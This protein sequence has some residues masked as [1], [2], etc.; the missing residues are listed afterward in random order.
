MQKMVQRKDHKSYLKIKQL[1][2]ETVEQKKK[3]ERKGKKKTVHLDKL[4]HIKVHNS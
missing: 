4:P 1:R 3:Q 2:K